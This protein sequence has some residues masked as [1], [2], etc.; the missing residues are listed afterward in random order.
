M[1]FRD[2]VPVKA[3]LPRLRSEFKGKDAALVEGAF[4]PDP[5]C[6]CLHDAPAQIKAKTSAGI[7]ATSFT[8][9]PEALE[10]FRLIFFGYS[11]A[12]IGDADRCLVFGLTH[13][14]HNGAAF[15]RVF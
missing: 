4:A 13:G 7:V 12:G 2:T 3:G 10:Q 8:S 5:S 15:R 1:R 14:D 11:F 9:L 6:V